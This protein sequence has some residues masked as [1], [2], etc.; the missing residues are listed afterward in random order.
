MFPILR[1]VKLP[2]KND[3]KLA[4][5]LNPENSFVYGQDGTKIQG[6]TTYYFVRTLK[7][8]NPEQYRSDPDENAMDMNQARNMMMGKNNPWQ[9]GGNDPRPSAKRVVIDGR[10]RVVYVGSRGAEY[11]KKNGAFIRWGH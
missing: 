5:A 2:S 11:V 3:D 6:V 7:N 4:L 10:K 1:I 8:A 9:Q